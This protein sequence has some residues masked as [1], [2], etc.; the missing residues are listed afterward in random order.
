MKNTDSSV[1]S[2]KSVWH[3]LFPVAFLGCVLLGAAGCQS[4]SSQAPDPAWAG[5]YAL[6]SV[7]GKAVP[8]TVQHEGRNLTIRSG[9][10]ILA[11]DGSATSQMWLEGRDAPMEVRATSSRDGS[12]LTLK[13]QGAGLTRGSVASNVFTMTNEGMVL[14]Y[15]R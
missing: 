5:T 10:F 7:D 3:A 1:H 11:P 9:S 6:A 2:S 13:W 8:C 14:V 12:Q 4:K 15:R